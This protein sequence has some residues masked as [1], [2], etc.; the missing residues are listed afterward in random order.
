MFKDK[1]YDLAKKYWREFLI[2]VFISLFGLD[3]YFSYQYVHEAFEQVK[4][5]KEQEVRA[6]LSHR[7]MLRS[8]TNF[9]LPGFEAP[10]VERIT[11]TAEQMGTPWWVPSGIGR[12]EKGG[13]GLEF[14]IQDMPVDVTLRYP[15]QEWQ[16]VFICRML[17]ES[18]W[19]VI[20]NDPQL[21]AKV[22]LPFANRYNKD[23]QDDWLIKVTS[24]MGDYRNIDQRNKGEIAAVKERTPKRIKILKKNGKKFFKPVKKF[25]PTKKENRNEKSP[26]HISGVGVQFLDACFR[27]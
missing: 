12:H 24:L 8:R 9:V 10:L 22:L 2:I 26:E 21:M 23:N 14:G 4:E 13:D 6:R 16:M 11:R 3:K 5:S 7:R 20:V 25:T 1:V 17:N 15:V 19:R 18:A 27:C